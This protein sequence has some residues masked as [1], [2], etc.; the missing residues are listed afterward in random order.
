M[1]ENAD[2]TKAVIIM[3][4]I[5]M[6]VMPLGILSICH[7]LTFRTIRENTQR[8]NAISSHQR[9]D[10]AM[11]MLFFIIIAC[12]V[13]SHS[14]KFVLNFFEI[15]RLFI[16]QSAREWPLWAF[17]LTRINHLLLVVNSSIN[18]FIYCFRDAKF[19]DAL[20]SLLG[21]QIRLG[22]GGS[23][24]SLNQGGSGRSGS[25]RNGGGGRSSNHDENM[26]LTRIVDLNGNPSSSLGGSAS[27][28]SSNCA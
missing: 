16:D 10:N 1:R 9:R 5:V 23:N 8:H 7:V 3:N 15:S 12:F 24:G 27:G 6:V 2:Y 26:E 11:A 13:L 17:L 18:F 21:I 25:V 14:G 19:R 20:F 22:T 28:V 4:F